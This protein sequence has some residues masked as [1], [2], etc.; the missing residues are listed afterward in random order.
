METALIHTILITDED[1][2]DVAIAK[3]ILKQTGRDMKITAVSRWETAI[4]LLKAVKDL[5]SL[6]LLDIE[7]PGIGGIEP[8]LE[9][10]ASEQL[11]HLPVIVVTNSSLKADREEALVAGADDVFHK[12]FNVEQF[13]K[14]IDSLLE[15]YIGK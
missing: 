8:L 2:H 1:P 12:T 14:E 13:R 4:E 10:R 6:I 7:M 9:I 3:L 5:P 15:C 11:K